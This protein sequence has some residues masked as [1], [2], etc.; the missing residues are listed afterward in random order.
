MSLMM[1]PACVYRATDSEGDT[2][3]ISQEEYEH[4]K[5]QPDLDDFTRPAID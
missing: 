4:L 3:K 5:T 1:L 2:R